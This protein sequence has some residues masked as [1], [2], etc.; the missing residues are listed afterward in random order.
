LRAITER[1]AL[2]TYGE[3]HAQLSASASA[4]S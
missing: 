1:H 2:I 4:S 3:A